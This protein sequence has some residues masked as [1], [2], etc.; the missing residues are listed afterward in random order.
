MI[1]VFEDTHGTIAIS[2]HFENDPT[3]IKKGPAKSCGDKTK[4]PLSFPK[5]KLEVLIDCGR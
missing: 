4:A 5:G 2:S 1:A 3:V